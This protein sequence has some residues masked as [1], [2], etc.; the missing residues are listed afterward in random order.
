MYGETIENHDKVLTI[1]VMLEFD[2]KLKLSSPDSW[3]L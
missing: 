1:I 2:D 3:S